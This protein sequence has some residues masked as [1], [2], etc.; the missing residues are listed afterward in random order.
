[1]QGATLLGEPPD[2]VRKPERS[3]MARL[4][5]WG[6]SPPAKR[7]AATLVREGQSPVVDAGAPGFQSV[8]NENKGTNRVPQGPSKSRRLAALPSHE[9]CRA[10]RGGPRGAARRAQPDPA[11]LEAPKG[12]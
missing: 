7:S 12:L 9:G 1:M 6:R 8:A 4:V 2:Q 11:P 5:R 3:E 10:L